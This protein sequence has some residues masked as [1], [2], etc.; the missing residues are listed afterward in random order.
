VSTRKAYAAYLTVEKGL[1]PN[2]VSS[3]D[4]DLARFE[5]F[6][7][8]RGA[9]LETFTRA[10]VVDYVERLMDEGMAVASITRAISSIR[11][12]TRYLLLT[13]LIAEDPAENL[14]SPRRWE[15]LPK[16]LSHGQMKDLLASRATGRL[17]A[18][19]EA[20][21][22]LMYSSGL[23][24]SEL[25]RLRLGDM[26]LDAGYLRVSGKG[27]KERVV[28]AA[29]HAIEA[30]RRYLDQ[31]RPRL[32][33]RRNSDFAFLTARGRPLTR[34]R[35][36]QTLKALGRSAGV[37]ISPHVLRHSFATH[38]LEGGADLR[39]LQ[40]MLGHSD[41]STTQIYTKVSL[42]RTRRVYRAYHPRA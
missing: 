13:G 27:D 40:E 42:D 31:L 6:L 20:M 25:V 34:Q 16:A 14:P 9:A 18:R 10:H 2:S 21:V 37:E 36:W 24:V 11:G 33:G 28:P 32:L 4:S 35:F 15:K 22:E 30:V 8:P 19:D 26:N 17:A 29:R 41:I 38:M 3:Y 5:T 1:A 7:S 39:S 23:R 12:L